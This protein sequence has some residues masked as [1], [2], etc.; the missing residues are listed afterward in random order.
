MSWYSRMDF[1]DTL[2]YTD[3][4]DPTYVPVSKQQIERSKDLIKIWESKLPNVTP[5]MSPCEDTLS[6]DIVVCAPVAS[7]RIEPEH[8]TI[9]LY[10]KN[11]GRFT[12]HK[13]L[14]YR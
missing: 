6:N 14:R 8:T 3:P 2:G 13:H 1:L 12:V 7:C 5:C 11:E 9:N 10:T 4:E